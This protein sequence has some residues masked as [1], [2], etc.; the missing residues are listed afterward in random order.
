[1]SKLVQSNDNQFINSSNEINNSVRFGFFNPNT[2][3]WPN[4]N[5]FTDLQSPVTTFKSIT[6]PVK[7]Q[8][9]RVFNKL[10]NSKIDNSINSSI[11]PK[12]SYDSFDTNST[13]AYSLSDRDSNM[14]SPEHNHTNSSTIWSDSVFDYSS[15]D[16]NLSSL[17]ANVDQRLISPP[18]NSEQRLINSPINSEQNKIV[19]KPEVR[20]S[21]QN[22]SNALNQININQ[23]EQPRKITKNQF[24]ENNSN[25]VS[26]LNS[27]NQSTNA[28]LIQSF[29]AL[30][31]MSNRNVNSQNNN[32]QKNLNDLNNAQKNLNDL[33]NVNNALNVDPNQ[34]IRWLNLGRMIDALCGQFGTNNLIDLLIANA[35]KSTGNLKIRCFFC[36]II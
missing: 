29:S 13:F 30:D 10:S 25:L 2:Y 26:D 18:I 8:S 5:Q 33:N 36:S 11:Y 19:S 23:I 3:K 14:G 15:L 1:M 12:N 31:L 16:S 17:P 21:N 35:N 27:T 28:N 7:I 9:N 22:R 24:Y 4:T 6:E 32:A 34:L 20:D